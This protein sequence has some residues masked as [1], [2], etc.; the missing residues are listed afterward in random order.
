MGIITK[1]R[2]QKATWWKST[3]PDGFGQDNFDAPAEISVRWEDRAEQV[4][5]PSG[6]EFVSRS[7]VYVDRD[8]VKPG[9]WLRLGSP[10]SAEPATPYG[11][12]GAYPVRQ[13]RNTPKLNLTE[14]LYERFL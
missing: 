4:L 6:E 2:K 12:D 3:G 9:D 10:A 5:L 8:E 14:T 11:V 7:V 1:M 13:K